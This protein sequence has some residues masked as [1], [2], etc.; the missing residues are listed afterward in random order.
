[1]NID[2]GFKV[3][4]AVIVLFLNGCAN[5]TAYRLKDPA[6][7]IATNQFGESCTEAQASQNRAKFFQQCKEIGGTP[8]LK[9]QGLGLIHGIQCILPSG[10]VRDLYDEQYFKVYGVHVKN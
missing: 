10:A 6:T 4:A 8:Q 5:D 1:M 2:V 7:C 9:S 3:S